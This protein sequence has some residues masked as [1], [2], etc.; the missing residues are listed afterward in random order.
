MG[1]ISSR[2][3]NEDLR[4]HHNRYGLSSRCPVPPGLSSVW[5]RRGAKMGGVKT[6]VSPEDPDQEPAF[7][8]ARNDGPM[9]WGGD[10]LTSFALWFAGTI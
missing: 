8:V 1:G 10:G 9:I 6:A 2:F 3:I 7:N 5:Q 4:D